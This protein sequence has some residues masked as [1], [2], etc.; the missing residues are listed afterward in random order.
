MTIEPFPRA[1]TAIVGAATFGL[2]EAPGWSSIALAAQA[3]KLA[4][5]DAGLSL[6]EVDALFICTPDDFLAGLTF[7]ETLGLRPKFTDNNRT[8][9]SAF[10]SHA[11]TAAMMLD[12]GMIN[13]ALI[14]HGSNQRTGAGGKLVSA[15]RS[16]SW[17]APYNPLFR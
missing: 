12:A 6:G 9:G 3:S 8:G 4:L 17:E 7:A 10:M 5:A 13:T 2:G 16:S 14:A 1:K 11:I 15:A